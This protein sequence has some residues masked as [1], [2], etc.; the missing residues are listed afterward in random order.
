MRSKETRWI[1][2]M[3]M[4]L[5]AG[6]QRPPEQAPPGNGVQCI[7]GLLAVTTLLLTVSSSDGKSGLLPQRIK[8][9]AQ[10]ANL[11]CSLRG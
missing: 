9:K 8:S 3:A 1:Q 2:K 10:M 11:K 5:L 6:R 7:I 4:R